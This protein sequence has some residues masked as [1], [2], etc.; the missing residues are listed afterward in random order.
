MDYDIPNVSIISLYWFGKFKKRLKKGQYKYISALVDQTFILHLICLRLLC[1]Y[2]S[3]GEI[4]SEREAIANELETTLDTATDPWG[5]KVFAQT[6][7][8]HKLIG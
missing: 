1:F 8:T 5:I 4:L 7:Y 3:L 6:N 2:R